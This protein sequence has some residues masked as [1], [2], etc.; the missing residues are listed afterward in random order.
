MSSSELISVSIGYF[1][2]DGNCCGCCSLVTTLVIES[3]IRQ[4]TV[5]VTAILPVLNMSSALMDFLVPL[6]VRLI[7]L[8]VVSMKKIVRNAI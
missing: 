7:I 5:F 1:P 3:T 6:V 8:K 2:A 4:V